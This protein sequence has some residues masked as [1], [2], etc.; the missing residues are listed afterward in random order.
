MCN[1]PLLWPCF[2]VNACGVAV[3]MQCI[4]S[5]EGS[6]PAYIHGSPMIYP[7][8]CETPGIFLSSDNKRA[9]VR[10]HAGSAF[11]TDL[12]DVCWAHVQCILN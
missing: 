6:P 11:G 12:V 2:L 5:P 3:T 8:N 7:G 4:Q 1:P 9:T 10:S